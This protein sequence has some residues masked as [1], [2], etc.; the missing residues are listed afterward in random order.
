L[1][2]YEE[3]VFV[4]Y[5][6]FLELIEQAGGGFE[7]WCEVWNDAVGMEHFGGGFSHSGDFG[8]GQS[9]GVEANLV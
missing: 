5:S 7:F 3:E 8:G 6:D 1:W 9:A 4:F 2:S